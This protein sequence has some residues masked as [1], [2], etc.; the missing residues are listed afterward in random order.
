MT[1]P[2][3]LLTPAQAVER[4]AKAGVNVTEETVRQWAR[5]DQIRHTRLPSGRYLYPADAI[6]AIT[7]P[8]VGA[9]ATASAA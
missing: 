3:V 9:E 7:A 8:I 5:V 1:Q 4:L 2:P 6:D